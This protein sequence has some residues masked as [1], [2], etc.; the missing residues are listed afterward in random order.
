MPL[1]YEIP[2]RKGNMSLTIKL[3]D[4]G[5]MVK[6]LQAAL[7][8]SARAGLLVDGAFG[9]KTDVSLRAYQGAHGLVV[10]GLAG[11]ITL[12]LL[13]ITGKTVLTSTL[14]RFNYIAAAKELG[15]GPWMVHGIALQE[16]RADPFL[17]DGR[18][19]ILF[20]RHQFYKRMRDR[21]LAD[22]LAASERD[23][24]HPTMKS[25]KNSDPKDRY[26]GGAA[27][28]ALLE[29]AMQ[30]DA[31]AALESASYGQFQ[32]MGFNAVPIGYPTVEEF[33]RQM[34]LDV[35]YHLEAFVRFIKATPVAL[36]AIRVEDIPALSAAFNGAA[37]KVNQ[38]DVKLKAC[39]A[40]IRSLY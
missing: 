9:P 40:K 4:T 30:Y 35:S 3:N 27:E 5:V 39:I 34:Q 1:S 14:D 10:D 25:G 11:P 22:K 15:C 38:Y 16:T 33:V 13:G 24:C 36:K 28:W 32:V 7:N 19:R 2:P 17:V 37:Y 20:E 8:A 21:A 18:P 12:S 23:I 26:P 6:A 29:R 31:K